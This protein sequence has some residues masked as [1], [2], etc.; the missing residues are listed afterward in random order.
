MSVTVYGLEFRFAR[1]ARSEA[2]HV[3][4]VE[5]LA[6][7]AAR[8]DWLA[9]G[10]PPGLPGERI[11]LTYCVPADRRAIERVRWWLARNRPGAHDVD[12]APLAAQRRRAA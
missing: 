10:A 7:A 3:G 5:V 12:V 2:D 9:L 11:R 6:S 4:R 1:A 8:A